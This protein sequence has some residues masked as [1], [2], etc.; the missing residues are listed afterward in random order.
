MSL[1]PPLT[2]FISTVEFPPI[3]TSVLPL[4]PD[5]KD[6]VT[7]S[8]FVKIADHFVNFCDNGIVSPVFLFLHRFNSCFPINGMTAFQTPTI[9][10]VFLMSIVGSPSTKTTSALNPAA[11]L[12]RSFNLNEAP[13]STLQPRAPLYLTGQH[14]Q[15]SQFLMHR[16]SVDGSRIRRVCPRKDRHSSLMERQDVRLEHIP[17]AF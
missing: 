4:Q 1:A 15:H 8:P 16:R 17:P 13:A 9:A 12:P 3:I 6:A 11:I 14:Q 2:T 7:F 10:P 5:P